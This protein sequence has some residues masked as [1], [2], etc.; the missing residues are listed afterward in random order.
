[1]SLLAF[2]AVVHV[3]ACIILV[4]LVLI[5][6]SKG[7]GVFNAQTSSNSFLGA[8]GATTLAGNM[9]KIVAGIVAITCI[10][11]AKFSVDS[12]RSIVDSGVM[13]GTATTSDTVIPSA[14]APAPAP[15]TTQTAAPAM[16]APAATTE[17]PKK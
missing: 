12:K 10:A 17:A 7:G 1:M 2:L 9:T 11:I 4:G 6:D 3:L 8:T 14:S 15:T 16:A 13:G 5:Q